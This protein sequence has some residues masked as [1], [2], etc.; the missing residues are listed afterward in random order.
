[1]RDIAQEKPCI[2]C[3]N[4]DGKIH[5]VNGGEPIPEI[6]ITCKKCELAGPYGDTSLREETLYHRVG[7]L[8]FW[9]DGGESSKTCNKF[10]IQMQDET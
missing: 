1:M 10:A 6:A 2:I 8:E 7:T 5:R 9:V 4:M 3:V